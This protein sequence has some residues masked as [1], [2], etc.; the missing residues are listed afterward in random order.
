MAL[1]LLNSRL[2]F[3]VTASVAEEY[4]KVHWNH[5]VYYFARTIWDF[6]FL[7]SKG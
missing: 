2:S 7:Y 1:E 4:L 6:F 3:Q 5:Y